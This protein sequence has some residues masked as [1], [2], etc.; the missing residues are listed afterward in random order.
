MMKAVS[1][2]SAV[3]GDAATGAIAAAAFSTGLA[4]VKLQLYNSTV[5]AFRAF[6]EGP[7]GEPAADLPIMADCLYGV[8]IAQAL[9]L[10]PLW[11]GPFASHLAEEGRANGSPYGLTVLTGRPG[12]MPF[13]DIDFTTWGMAGPTFSM[14]ALASGEVTDPDIALAPTRLFMDNARSR[15]RDQWN[16]AGLYSG[17]SWEKYTANDDG[18]PWCTNHYGMPLW[19]Y[20]VHLGI[21]GQVA[22]IPAGTLSFKSAYA[23]P[24]TV[25]LLLAGTTGAV[26][27]VG[28]NITVSLAFGALA[29]PAGGLV[30]DDAPCPHAVDLRKGGSVSWSAL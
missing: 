22:N 8:S 19:H 5:G 17:A 30:V 1:A 13:A 9:G 28:G 15:L 2:L 26:T 16:L 29:L 14:V 6:S 24:Y 7:P 23:P 11:D 21:S 20:V 10:G 12:A 18:A 4:A 25:P 27:R 3:V